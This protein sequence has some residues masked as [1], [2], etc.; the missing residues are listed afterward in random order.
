MVLF[1][2]VVRLERFLF[3]KRFTWLQH[4]PEMLAFLSNSLPT[5]GDSMGN[6]TK[7]MDGWMTLRT[8][9]QVDCAI[10]KK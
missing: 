3:Q 5:V 6:S 7:F 2:M 9:P 10:R 1:G 8:I 4:L